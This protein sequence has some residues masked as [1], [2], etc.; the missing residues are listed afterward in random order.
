MDDLKNPMPTGERT[1]GKVARLRVRQTDAVPLEMRKRVREVVGFEVDAEH[2]RKGY[3]TRLMN[4]V[5]EEADA[6]NIVLVL[7]PDPYGEDAAITAMTQEQL[8]EWYNHS[9]GFAVL[10]MNPILMARMPNSKPVV[11]R[12]N[13]V[14]EG[15]YK[16]TRS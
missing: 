16:G 11:M 6:A 1:V 14:T 12:L 13:K 8:V 7:W 4:K 2:Q 15:I 3:G 9:F 5:C 10:Q